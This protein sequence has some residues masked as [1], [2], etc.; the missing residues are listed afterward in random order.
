MKVLITGA[1]G[2]VGKAITKV[3]LTRG[4]AVNYLTTSKNKMVSKENYNGF[5]WNPA[6]GEIDIAC[7]EEVSAI[8]NLAGASIADKWT[9]AYKKKV[10]SSRVDSLQT[11]HDGLKKIDASQ[12]K[13]FV[14]AS[15]IGIYPSSLFSYYD[16]KETAVDDSF[17]GEVVEEWEEK[18]DTLKVFDFNLAKIRIGIV[19]SAEGGALPRMAM[20]VKNYVGA[21]FGNGK[22]WQSWIHIDDLANMFVFALENR[23]RGTFNAVAPN[24][25]TNSKMTKELAKVLK[26]PL[27]LPNVPKPVMELIL[28]EMSYLLFASHR[29]SSKRIEKKGFNFEFS[30]ICCAIEDLYTTEKTAACETKTASLNEELV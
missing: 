29:V 21:A 24:P 13:S 3:L 12:I 17:L 19:L 23:L 4:I 25:V 9:T 20:P 7:F 15:A 2:L 16:E 22:Q 5:Y 11:L 14:S 8:I 30:N 28:G 18:I 27:V 1:T 6:D 10:L 26:K